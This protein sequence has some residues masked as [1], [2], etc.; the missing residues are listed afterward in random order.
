M[1]FSIILFIGLIC[2]ALSKPIYDTK[3]SYV[4]PVTKINVDK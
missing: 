1:K 2:L 4:T 3:K